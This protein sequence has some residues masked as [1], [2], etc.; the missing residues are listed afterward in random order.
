MIISHSVLLLM[1]GLYIIIWLHCYLLSEAT[2]ALQESFGPRS[3]RSSIEVATISWQQLLLIKASLPFSTFKKYRFPTLQNYALYVPLPCVFKQRRDKTHITVFKAPWPL[4]RLKINAWDV[5]CPEN[6]HILLL[7]ASL[8]VIIEK[9][10]VHH[11]HW[12]KN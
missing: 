9:H 2:A 1:H 10:K 12:Q 3:E 4:T 6:P 8:M 11:S 7:R 5:M